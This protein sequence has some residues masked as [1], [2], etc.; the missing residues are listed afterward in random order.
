MKDTI[1]MSNKDRLI[2]VTEAV[3][4]RM[5]IA[6]RNKYKAA[7]YFKT[8]VTGKHTFYYQ[9]ENT[10]Q[11]VFLFST[12]RYAPSVAAF[13][14]EKG[15]L[16]CDDRSIQTYSITFGELYRLKNYHHNYILNKILNRIKIWVN[17]VIR[18]ELDAP[19]VNISEF[20]E[21]SLHS[22]SRCWDD[23]RAA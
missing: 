15:V 5:K 10:S 8:V 13:F 7:S 11:R 17:D 6:G 21:S 19:A 9:P 16:V 1:A 20:R 2:C 22:Q 4:T 12:K 18:Y 14:A 3:A 23:G